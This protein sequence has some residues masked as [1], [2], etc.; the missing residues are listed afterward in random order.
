[1]QTKSI[2]S[3]IFALFRIHSDYFDCYRFSVANRLVYNSTIFCGHAVQGHT[4]ECIYLI[5]DIFFDSTRKALKILR[6][7]SVSILGTSFIIYSFPHLYIRIRNKV[8]FLF[9]L[10]AMSYYKTHFFL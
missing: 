3:L 6:N 1:M 9:G 4:N 7:F 5:N 2:L 8:F 10:L